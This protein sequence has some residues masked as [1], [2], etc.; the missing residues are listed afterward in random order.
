MPENSSK[1][2]GDARVDAEVEGSGA[3]ADTRS[4]GRKKDGGSGAGGD[5]VASPCTLRSTDGSN[6]LPGLEDAG[7][8]SLWARSGAVGWGRSVRAIPA[9]G[10]HM[11]ARKTMD[12]FIAAAHATFYS[13]RGTAP[14]CMDAANA[15]GT[16]RESDRRFFRA[17]ARGDAMSFGRLERPGEEKECIPYLGVSKTAAAACMTIKVKLTVDQRES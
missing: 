1:L 8:A 13:K 14:F 7:I 9:S 16:E 17:A 11:W 12:K 15:V 6:C 4:E 3:G 2:K 10:A 5:M